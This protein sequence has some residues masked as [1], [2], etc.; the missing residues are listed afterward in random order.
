M[1]GRERQMD[2]SAGRQKDPWKCLC[3]GLEPD[4]ATGRE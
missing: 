1:P 2:G 4:P 3:D